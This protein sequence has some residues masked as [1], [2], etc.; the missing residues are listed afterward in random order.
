MTQHVK[1]DA[2]AKRDLQKRPTKELRCITQHV[3]RD[4]PAKRDLQKRPIKET[5]ARER[6]VQPLASFEYVR[7]SA[8][9]D[10][11]ATFQYNP[12]KRPAYTQ[13]DLQQRGQQQ[14]DQ[15]Q[16]DLQQRDLQQ[17]DQ[18]QRD[19]QQSDERRRDRQKRDASN[20]QHL[21]NTRGI[22]CSRKKKK[23]F[24]SLRFWSCSR[25]SFLH[26]SLR[27]EVP[28]NRPYTTYQ[29]KIENTK[30]DPHRDPCI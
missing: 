4:A 16:K 18:R 6:C 27:C 7:S 2:S 24:R 11:K 30:R 15:Q 13:R 17:R 8:L 28:L 26:S 29:K 25:V 3:K 12:S 23:L 1:R 20:N 19:L 14:R 22:F 10:M 5:D 9:K 21:F